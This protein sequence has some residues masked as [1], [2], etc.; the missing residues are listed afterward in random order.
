MTRLKISTRLSILIGVLILLL[1]SISCLGIASTD[2]MKSSLK[3]IYEDRVVALDQLES[4]SYLIQR[5]R[6]LIMDMLLI[7]EPANIGKR[8]REIRRNL[9]QIKIKWGAYLGTYLTPLEIKLARDFSHAKDIY[10]DQ[11]LIPTADAILKG[12]FENAI[13]LYRT[14]VSPLAPA[15]HE[16]MQKLLQLQIDVARQEYEDAARSYDV[17][18]IVSISILATAILFALSFGYLLVSGITSQLGGEP[19]EAANLAASVATGNLNNPVHILSG[20]TSSLML[21]LQIMQKSLTTLVDNV[22]QGA[23]AVASASAQ[24]AQDSNSLSSR[25][26]K[27]ASALQQTAASMYALDSTVKQNS[28]SSRYAN[29]I[30]VIVSTVAV[31]GGSVVEQVVNTMRE[32]ADASRKICDIIGVID[33]IAFQTNILSI[34]AAVEAS[35][36]GTQG[37]GFAVVAS[38]VRSLAARSALAAKEI[39][40]LINSSL[41]RVERGTFQAAEAGST[42][43]EVV[44]AVKQL[45]KMM[46]EISS[47]SVEQSLGV[48]QIGKAVSQMEQTTQQNLVLVE[49]M[50]IAASSLKMQAN[51]LVGSV[52]VFKFDDTTR[53]HT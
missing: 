9:E 48:A 52:A 47:A 10:L 46:S 26:E 51:E 11:G 7:Q 13:T 3:T 25:T 1:F 33:D 35:R 43:T 20:D 19:S 28:N 44:T 36:A 24:I 37:R 27:Q 17:M 40:S 50:A 53:T 32:I 2:N 22:L 23:E 14:K 12:N 38:E 39:K 21:Q 49:E 41:E 42:I 4:V 8:D 45:T 31:R 6:V 29:Q 15:S 30:A 18:R 5:N 16:G 34:N